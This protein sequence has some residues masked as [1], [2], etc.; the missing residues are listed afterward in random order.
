MKY[1]EKLKLKQ[2]F[3]N[4]NSI[5]PSLTFILFHIFSYFKT[6]E[7]D[8]PLH[9]SLKRSLSFSQVSNSFAYAFR[10][11]W[12]ILLVVATKLQTSLGKGRVEGAAFWHASDDIV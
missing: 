10:C 7:S 8:I 5:P 6:H 3:L 9:S 12:T 11:V 1:K 4:Y 2:D